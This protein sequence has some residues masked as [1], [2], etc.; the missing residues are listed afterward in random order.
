MGNKTVQKVIFEDFKSDGLFG[1]SRNCLL[2]FNSV[3]PIKLARNI[4]KSN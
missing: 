4:E 1:I 2:L 3:W